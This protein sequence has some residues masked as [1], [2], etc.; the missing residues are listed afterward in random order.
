MKWRI[1][2]E[3]NREVAKRNGRK[4]PM[5]WAIFEKKRAC[6]WGKRAEE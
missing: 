3:S 5:K 2:D 6:R 4:F 1:F